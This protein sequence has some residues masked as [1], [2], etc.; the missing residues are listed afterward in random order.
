MS[1]PF[2][3]VYPKGTTMRFQR[4]GLAVAAALSLGVSG[5]RAQVLVDPCFYQRDDCYER[6]RLRAAQAEERARRL[7]DQR[8]ERRISAANTP[9]VRS[10]AT[11]EFHERMRERHEEARL[12]TQRRAWEAQERTW[13]R[14]LEAQLRTEERARVTR[15]A[16]ERTWESQERA[17]EARE[18]QRERQE[19]LR[20]RQLERSWE[21]QERARERQRE[22]AERRREAQLRA[23]RIRWM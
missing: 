9:S 1:D 22:A 6:A 7:E 2:N 15:E 12:E 4:L 3:P 5:A 14:A 20:Q 17:R 10:L 8:F 13:Q 21:M 16:R 19:E 18:R 23:A 11:P